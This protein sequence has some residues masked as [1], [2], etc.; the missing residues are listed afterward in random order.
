MHDGQAEAGKLLADPLDFLY[1]DRPAAPLPSSFKHSSLA[2]KYHDA[3]YGTITLR[4]EPH[5]DV[6]GET[7][8][9]AD[10]TDMSFQYRIRLHRVSG[11]YWVAYYYQI[12]EDMNGPEDARRAEFKAGV[13]G[14]PSGLEIDMRPLGDV[15]HGI[16]FF[17]KAE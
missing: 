16:V 17:E 13:D 10:R 1:P 4:E 2:G 5:P 14:R 3:G 9:V 7:I 12:S 6:A 8:L 15:S 11:D